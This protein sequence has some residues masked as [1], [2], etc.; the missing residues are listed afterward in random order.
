M[1]GDLAAG[2]GQRAPADGRAK[3]REAALPP[4]RF[5]GRRLLPLRQRGKLLR[6]PRALRLQPAL[7]SA[8]HGWCKRLYNMCMSH[9]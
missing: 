2:G 5:S 9:L 4:Q 7:S 1:W 6:L 8:Q 3:L